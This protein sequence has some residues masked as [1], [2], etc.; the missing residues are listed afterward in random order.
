M[1]DFFKMDVFFIVATLATIVLVA[2]LAWILVRILR[3]LGNVEKITDSA[4]AET[5][6]F[7][8][9]I[10]DVRKGV[11]DEGLKLKHI[12]QFAR[13]ALARWLGVTRRKKD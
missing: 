2:L 5:E 12:V 11:R 1:D 4:A 7:R 13:R 8:A 3:I 9:D 6:L 10:A